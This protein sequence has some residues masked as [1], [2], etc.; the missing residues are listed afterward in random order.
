MFISDMHLVIRDYFAT[1]KKIQPCLVV[2]FSLKE[3]QRVMAHSENARD[4]GAYRFLWSVDVDNLNLSAQIVFTIQLNSD[5][6][7]SRQEWP[8]ARSKTK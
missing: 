7:E 3:L 4:D 8:H 6:Q 2:R 5:L 1:A